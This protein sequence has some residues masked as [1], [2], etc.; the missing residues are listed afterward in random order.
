VKGTIIC[1]GN[2]FVEED[3]AGLQVFDCIQEMRP[4]PSGIELVEGGLAGL[5]LLPLLEQGGRVVFVDAVRGFAQEGE[6][7][8]LSYREIL[9]SPGQFRFGHDAGLPYLLAVLPKVCDG[10]LPEDIVLLGLEGRCVAKTLE[11]A[12]KMS[13]AIAEHGLRDLG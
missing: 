3:S 9:Q 13:I 4:L 7:V 10:E 1:I 11:K 5:N 2:R 12:A 8:V 6:I